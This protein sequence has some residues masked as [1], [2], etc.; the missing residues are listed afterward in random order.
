MAGVSIHDKAKRNDCR[1]NAA[2]GRYDRTYLAGHELQPD[3]PTGDA[4]LVS[5]HGPVDGPLRLP[6]DDDP[7]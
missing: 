4:S 1:A 2:Q 6:D 7:C 5:Q 3:L